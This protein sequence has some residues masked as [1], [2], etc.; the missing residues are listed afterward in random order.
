MLI[1]VENKADFG[2]IYD[3]HAH[4]DDAKF[5]GNRQE[6]LEELQNYG[7]GAIINNSVD[8]DESARLCLDMSRKFDFCYTALGLHPQTVEEG[9]D[10]EEEKLRKLLQDNKI[11]AIGEI[12]LDYYWSKD[13]KEQQIEI[14][15]RQIA[16]A[17]EY[18]LPIIVH[19]REAHADTLEILKNYAPKGTVHCFSGS[20]EMAE[21]V[22]K[23]G[24]YIGVGGVVTFSNAKKLKEVV[25]FYP[26]QKILLETDAPYLAP[27]PYRGSICNSAQLIRVAE[28]IAEIKGLTTTEVLN[29]T[30]DNAK[31][32]YNLK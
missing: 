26:I 21:E 23:L 12:G 28:T 19:D 24:M 8:F 9:K 31:Q 20:V 32:L 17:K 4:Y 13:R 22:L 18:G 6:I 2:T 5:D 14:F 16:I 3:T 1:Q 15:S 30:K 11:V 7:V 10:L 29:T 25:K 27:V